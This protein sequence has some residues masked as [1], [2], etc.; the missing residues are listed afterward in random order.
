MPLET[1]PYTKEFVQ[2]G[3]QQVLSFEDQ[4]TVGG[5]VDS[6]YENAAARIT[7]LGNGLAYCEAKH[8]GVYGG[9]GSYRDTLVTSDGANLSTNL[10]DSFVGFNVPGPI[11]S[12]YGLNAELWLIDTKKSRILA[13]DYT[14]PLAAYFLPNTVQAVIDDWPTCSAPRHTRQ[15]NVLFTDGHAE[16][17]FPDQITRRSATTARTTGNRNTNKDVHARRL[18]C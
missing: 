12:G 17:K 2:P 10:P 3:T 4:R 11:R 9:G 14:K 16:P 5:G 1:G 6:S 15:C 8:G 7:D 18:L 13:L